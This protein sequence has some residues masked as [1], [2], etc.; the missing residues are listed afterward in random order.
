[1]YIRLTSRC[2]MTCRHCAF[3]CTDR[4]RDIT[5][6]TFKAALEL[7]WEH[8]TPITLGGGEPTLH[9][10][11]WELLGL[12]LSNPYRDDGCAPFLVTNG[13]IT[14]TAL[15][16]AGLAKTGAVCVSLS[17]DAYHDPIDPQVVRAFTKPP[18]S[19][20]R[21]DSGSDSRA[22]NPLHRV[23]A[24]GRAQQW[25]DWDSCFCDEL[26]VQP[27]GHLWECGCFRRPF[28]TVFEP[29]L[30]ESYWDEEQGCSKSPTKLEAA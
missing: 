21:M 24:A 6:E 12:A 26:I 16:L 14:M 1:M 15:A 17:Q 11:F 2:N 3:F 19:T 30:P 13:K 25:G 22:L 18:S 4:G 7:A 29:Q 10:Q 9:P 28:G 8:N 27:S 20:W 23:V 5:V